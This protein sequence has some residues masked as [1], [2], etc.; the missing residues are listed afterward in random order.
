MTIA[1]ISVTNTVIV[2]TMTLLQTLTLF[3]FTLKTETYFIAKSGI[4]IAEIYL[5]ILDISIFNF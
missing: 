3:T 2:L 5:M 4:K 1:E